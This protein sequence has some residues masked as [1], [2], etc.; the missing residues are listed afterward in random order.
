MTARRK[1]LVIR[2]WTL[3]TLL[4]GYALGWLWRGKHNTK[5][6]TWL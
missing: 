1:Q 3:G 4:V 6:H 5:E 2:V